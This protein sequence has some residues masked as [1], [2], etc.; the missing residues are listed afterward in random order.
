MKQRKAATASRRMGETRQHQVGIVLVVCRL[1]QPLAPLREEAQHCHCARSVVR[2]CTTCICIHVY[3]AGMQC[4]LHVC[5]PVSLTNNLMTVLQSPSGCA[6]A[7][8]LQILSLIVGDGW[9]WWWWCWVL[10]PILN[11]IAPCWRG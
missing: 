11:R 4:R 7:H 8:A 10:V 9:W 1:T 5:R 6:Y 3:L 2:G